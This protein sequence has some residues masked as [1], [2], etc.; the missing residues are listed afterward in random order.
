M[1]LEAYSDVDWVESIVDWRLTIGYYTFLGENLVTC[2][3]KKQSIVAR[4]CIEVEFR[5]MS[6]IVK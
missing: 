3:S 2:R 4:P 5:F 1:E 6:C